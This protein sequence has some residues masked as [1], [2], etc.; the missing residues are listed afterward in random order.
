M[1][2][3]MPVYEYRCAGCGA[4]ELWRDHQDSSETLCPGCGEEA[5]RVYSAPAVSDRTGVRGEVR[6]R[7][8]RGPEPSIGRRDSPGDPSPKPQKGGG[9]PWQIGH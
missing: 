5:R 1:G 3:K 7:M 8:D 4:F 6:R 2:F 9:R